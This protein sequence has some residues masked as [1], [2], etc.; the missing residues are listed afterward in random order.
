MTE[1]KPSECTFC[2]GEATGWLDLRL[3]VLNQIVPNLFGV[4]VCRY[5]ARHLKPGNKVRW[6][7]GEFEPW[8]ADGDG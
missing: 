5:H 4:A 8:E 2:H 3:K 6:S 1:E 7:V